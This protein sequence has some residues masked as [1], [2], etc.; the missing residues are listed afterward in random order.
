MLGKE[1]RIEEMEISQCLVVVGWT[2]SRNVMQA[3]VSY[4]L[5]CSVEVSG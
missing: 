5:G 4:N 1:G 3:S 2:E